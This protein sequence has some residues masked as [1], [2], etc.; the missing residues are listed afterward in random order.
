MKKELHPDYH[1]ITVKLTD[2]STY[3]TRSTYGS[4]G[5]SFVFGHRPICAP[6]LDWRQ[7]KIDGCWRTRFKVQKQ[8]RWSWLLSHPPYEFLKRRFLAA[9]FIAH[10]TRNAHI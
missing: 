2:G 8:I 5:D 7:P 9:F 3:E 1:M 4:E 6:S 10:V